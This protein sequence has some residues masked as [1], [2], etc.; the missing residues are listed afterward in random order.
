MKLRAVCMLNHME[1]LV[2]GVERIAT[3]HQVHSMYAVDQLCFFISRDISSIDK[4]NGAWTMHKKHER[5]IHKGFMLP[6]E[7]FASAI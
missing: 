3:G 2:G 4:T 1:R 7:S 6:A 5:S